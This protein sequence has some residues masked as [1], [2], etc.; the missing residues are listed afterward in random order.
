MYSIRG[1]Q[2]LNILNQ[3][4]TTCCVCHC[5]LTVEDYLHQ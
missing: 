1:N 4:D 2:Q 3:V 5:D